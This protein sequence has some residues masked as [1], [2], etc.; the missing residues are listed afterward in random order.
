MRYGKLFA[1]AAALCL[2]LSFH[3]SAAAQQAGLFLGAR[4]IAIS[5]PA[6]GA[7]AGV[8]IGM[9]ITK[10]VA[11]S[12]DVDLGGVSVRDSLRMIGHADIGLRIAPIQLWRVHP[13]VEVA[14]SSQ[15]LEPA[16]P[17]TVRTAFTAGVGSEIS[18]SETRSLL[19]SFR[20]TA[21][22]EGPTYR[23]SVGLVL[24]PPR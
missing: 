9:G 21:L 13:F 24:R 3:R 17:D 4:A 23:S 1:G 8:M 18:L 20:R 12:L 6:R 11:V 2:L 16:A 15:G 10:H 19:L 14:F 5:Q 7:G 22:S